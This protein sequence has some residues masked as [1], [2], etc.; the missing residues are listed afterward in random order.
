[1]VSVVEVVDSGPVTV[2]ITVTVDGGV[3]LVESPTLTTEYDG[4]A[5]R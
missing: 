3:V 4:V 5:R 2:L 1:M